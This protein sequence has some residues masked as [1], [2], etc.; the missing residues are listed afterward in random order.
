M[1]RSRVSNG[2]HLDRFLTNTPFREPS[3]RTR[4]TPLSCCAV[5]ASRGTTDARDTASGCGRS[6]CGS[7]DGA[8]G[9]RPPS[10]STAIR[11]FHDRRGALVKGTSCGSWLRLGRRKRWQS[12]RRGSLG[13]R[14]RALRLRLGGH[15]PRERPGEGEALTLVCLFGAFLDRLRAKDRTEA[16]GEDG[17]GREVK[18]GSFVRPWPIRRGRCSWRG[19]QWFNLFRSFGGDRQRCD[20]MKRSVLPGWRRDLRLDCQGQL[21]GGWTFRR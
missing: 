21:E 9:R 3:G 17:A 19:R 1:L 18:R 7:R 6:C 12:L 15:C 5:R 2:G 16:L 4:D 20:C 14:G 10:L 8:A 11:R 13:G